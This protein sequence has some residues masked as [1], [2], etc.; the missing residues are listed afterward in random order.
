MQN[1]TQLHP[2]GGP[3]RDS[4]G[5]ETDPP[6]FRGGVH[7]KLLGRGVRVAGWAQVDPTGLWGAR[8]TLCM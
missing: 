6:H 5:E 1:M 8:Q 2:F 4:H 3:C 7:G